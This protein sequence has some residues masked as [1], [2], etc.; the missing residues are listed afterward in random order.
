MLAL[1]GSCLLF[2]FTTTGLAQLSPYEQAK[3]AAAAGPLVAPRGPVPGGVEE[4][5][6]QTTVG[7]FGGATRSTSRS[8]AFNNADGSTVQYGTTTDAARGPF[9]AAVGRRTD[10]VMV[11]APSGNGY[12]YSSSSQSAAVGPRVP[13]PR[14]AYRSSAAV[15]GPY[16]AS[17]RSR[18]A[19][20]R[21]P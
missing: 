9:G 16:G 5:Y 20:R 17:Y 10:D 21:F 11:T 2:G 1:I 6:R 13:P 18:A 15:V 8:G 12:V 19:V 3:R 14:A 7:P 4:R